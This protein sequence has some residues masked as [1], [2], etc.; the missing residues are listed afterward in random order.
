MK[1]MSST[2]LASVL[3][4]VTA[5]PALAQ[6]AA[7]PAPPASGID[8]IVVTARR[9]EEVLSKVPAAVV[10][11]NADSLRRQGVQSEADLQSA[12]PGLT[13]RSTSGQNQTN[14]A[15]RGQSVDAFSSSPPGVVTYVNEVPSTANSATAFY[16][17]DR[18]QALKGPQGT[19]FGRNATGGAVLF[20][21]RRPGD[22]LGG[23]ARVQYGSQDRLVVEGAMDIP[24]LTDLLSIRI[25]GTHASGGAY[26]LNLY[27]HKKYGD[28]QADSGRITAV[29]KPAAGVTNTTIVQLSTFGGTNAPNRFLNVDCV[30]FPTAACTWSPGNTG[31]AAYI[32]AHPNALPAGFAAVPAYLDTFSGRVAD[33]EGPLGHFAKASYVA[34]ITE[35]ELSPS[36]TIKNIFGFDY[37]KSIEH[38]DYDS[39]PFPTL[40]NGG[41][42]GAPD[43]GLTSS[44]QFSNELQL[45]GKVL[46]NRLTYILGLFYSKQRVVNDSP[47]QGFATPTFYFAA[48][49]G[50]I[51][52]D[53]SKAAFTQL[54]YAVTDKINLTGGFRYTWDTIRADLLPGQTAFIGSGYLA[55]EQVKVSDPSW[56]ATLDYR[57]NSSLMFYVSSRGSW[58]AGGYNP[59]AA[60]LGDTVTAA[61]AGN[62]FKPERV[63]DVEG[64]MKFNGRVGGVPA[65]LNLA[66]YNS[67]L[68]DVQ[69][70]IYVTLQTSQ[71][72]IVASL[73]TNT[74]KAQVFGIEADFQVKPVDWLTLGGSANY[75]NARF[76]DGRS[77]L[78]GSAVNYGP[79]ADTPKFSGSAFAQVS[80][81]LAGNLGDVIVRGDVYHQSGFYFSNLGDT[82]NPGA[83]IP[84]YELLNARIDW[85]NVA[86]GPISLGVFGRNLTNKIY[87]TGGLPERQNSSGNYAAYGA[88]RQYGVEARV[89]F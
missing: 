84:G 11:L 1:H 19:L 52:T 27:D 58:R 69:R 28:R 36:A 3:A 72:P 79:Y 25:A 65:Q 88:P 59:F 89:K 77:V 30:N 48:R 83:Y 15:I 5:V 73:T 6:E 34:N 87:Y 50:Q 64:G 74:P 22:V 7:P 46:D 31:Y 63:R 38:Y 56:T 78:F 18:V 49:Y 29:L 24:L 4:L 85:N 32:A 61:S 41:T 43:G 55:T 9:R 10:A 20:Q 40:V 45:Q 86:G 14:F 62:Y 60:P 44:R 67:W 81:P 47:I 54:T 21:T 33:V 70:T 37:S 23:E 76:T 66:V 57:A 39:S 16:D 8:D 13:V 12:M 80:V 17:L 35:I 2:M 51:L 26:V 82:L 68:T 75:N 42:P 71:G 53:E